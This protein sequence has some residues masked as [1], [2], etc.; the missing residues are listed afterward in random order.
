MTSTT[1]AGSIGPQANTPPKLRAPHGVRLDPMCVL[2]VSTPTDL[3][4][5]WEGCRHV[6]E[7]AI[8]RKTAFQI[9][10]LMAHTSPMF[11]FLAMKSE[12]WPHALRICLAHRTRPTTHGLQYFLRRSTAF[13]RPFFK[14][15][16]ARS[17]AMHTSIRC[18]IATFPSP[19]FSYLYQSLVQSIS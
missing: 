15:C 19:L 11:A 14:F 8:R 7:T 12:P 5:S 9:A 6:A 2:L 18:L 16:H 3:L 17:L 1:N 10:H 4:L 13:P